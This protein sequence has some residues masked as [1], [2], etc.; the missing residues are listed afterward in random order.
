MNKHQVAIQFEQVASI[1]NIINGALKDTV[2]HHIHYELVSDDLDPVNCNVIEVYV[3]GCLKHT[4]CIMHIDH[5]VDV[6]HFEFPL[7]AAA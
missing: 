3:D 7:E 2:P 1:L 5:A 4:S 6:M